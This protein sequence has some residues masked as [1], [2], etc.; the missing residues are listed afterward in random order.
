MIIVLNYY[1]LNLLCQTKKQWAST[2]NAIFVVNLEASL[3]KDILLV[4][5]NRCEFER[6][7]NNHNWQ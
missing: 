3:S 5:A 2:Q 1:S 6:E 7:F 4:Q